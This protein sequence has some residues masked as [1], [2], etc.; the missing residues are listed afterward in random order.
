MQFLWDT[1]KEVLKGK[2]VKTAYMRKKISNR[3]LSCLLKKIE[4]STGVG[5]GFQLSKMKK[6]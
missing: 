1:A 5:V 3:Y 4:K 6:F 2:F